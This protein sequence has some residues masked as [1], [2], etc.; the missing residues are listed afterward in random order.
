MPD[1]RRP[2]GQSPAKSPGV[3]LVPQP[4]GGALRRGSRRGN[5]PGAGRPRNAVRERL[6]AIVDE[7]GVDFIRRVLRG[8]VQQITRA[9]EH[10]GEEPSMQTPED[11]AKAVPSISDRVAA[12]DRAA[13]Y[14]LGTT[15]ELTVEQVSVRLEAMYRVLAENLDPET[16]AR[17]DAELSRVW[18]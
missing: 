4:H 10:C 3:P 9:C 13:R 16:F 11:A 12:F 1:R 17:V 8:E 14:G 7:D 18:S 6:A 5:T 15:K 2:A